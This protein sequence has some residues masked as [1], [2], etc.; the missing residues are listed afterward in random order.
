M[1]YTEEKAILGYYLLKNILV[2]FGGVSQEHDVS[3]LTGVFTLNCLDPAQY[4]AVPVYIARDGCW[5]TGDEM[6][7]ISFFKDFDE[8]KVSRVTLLSGS[9]GLF[10]VK[11]NR[12]KK[13]L[14]AYCAINCLH[15]R[16]GEDGSLS[17]VLRLSGIPSASPDI[18]SLAAS[19]DK[20]KTKVMLDGAKI[21]SAP[22][23][24]VTAER[25]FS[26]RNEVIDGL[27]ERLS[28]PVIVKPSSSGSSIGISVA[29]TETEL[30]A[31]LDKAFRFDNSCLVESYLPSATDV[32]CAAFRRDGRIVVSEC[33]R[34]F[35]HGEFLSFDDKYSSSKYGA[36]KEFPAKIDLSVSDEI[37]SLT[38]KVY[39]LFGFTGV[40]RV[41][42]LLSG[43]KVYLNEINGVPGS[44][45]YYLFCDKIA[46][47]S[48]ML[49]EL[50]KEG[51]RAYSS[52]T[53]CSFEYGSDILSFKGVALKK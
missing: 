44:L 7:K 52:Y 33:E 27:K 2:F 18:F 15:G 1:F 46:D 26:A 36:A 42:Y 9:D 4:N 19:L 10:D 31:A 11:G 51:V 16:N 28:L 24:S 53:N 41:D 49:D 17:G 6:R 40:V 5:F 32:N 30:A 20:T 47:F 39:E 50:V 21:P 14:I 38:K 35:S 45:A 34:P 22:Y 23:E 43:G 13:L 37:K 12:L 3:V 29:K 8:K 48:V 25:F